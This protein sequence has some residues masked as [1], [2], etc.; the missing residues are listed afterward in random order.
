KVFA[1]RAPEQT[2]LF[3]AQPLAIFNRVFGLVIRFLDWAT[4]AVVQVFGLQERGGH[5]KVPSAAELRLLVEE[6][7][8]AGVLDE[9]EQ[10][11]LIN[12][13]A[14]ADSPASPASLPPT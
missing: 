13:F 7:G 14:F 5:T 9:D 11:M 12:V 10:A 6:S 3:I 8:E 2:A 1:I 4:D